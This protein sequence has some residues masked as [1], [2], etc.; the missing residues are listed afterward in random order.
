MAEAGWQ[1]ARV[2]PP[3]HGATAST[4][5]LW[6]PSRGAGVGT[7][8]DVTVTILS[9]RMQT[10]RSGVKDIKTLGSLCPCGGIGK[11]SSFTVVQTLTRSTY[12]AVFMVRKKKST[13]SHFAFE[14][15]WAKAPL[16]VQRPCRH[17]WAPL[18]LLGLSASLPVGS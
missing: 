8:G 14:N 16:P 2:L 9:G 18:G 12:L 4:P 6:F 13:W 11:E 3:P 17:P 7:A 1:K 5:E 15:K 10:Q